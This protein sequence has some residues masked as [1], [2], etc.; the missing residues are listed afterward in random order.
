VEKLLWDRQKRDKETTSVPYVRPVQYQVK[1][2]NKIPDP[3]SKTS[4]MIAF[5]RDYRY[6]ATALNR[7][8]KCPLQFYYSMVLGLKPKGEIT[9]DI[10]RD[11][12]GSFIH[13]I[14]RRYFLNKRGKPL[15]EEDLAIGEMDSLVEALFEKEYGKE[16]TGALYLLKRQVKRRMADILKYYYVPLSR[17]NELTILEVEESLEVRVDGF[18]LKG[19]LDSI[20]QRGGKTVIVDFKTGASESYLKINLEKLDIARRETWGQAI[21]SLQLP[22]YLLL[23][24]EKK[25]RPIDEFNALFLLLGRSRISEAIELSLFDDASPAETFVPLKAV[26]FKLLG[27][28]IDPRVPF[29]LAGDMKNGCP[30]CDFKYICG[31]PWVVK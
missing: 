30:T 25:R 4:E 21:G 20:E 18:N 2:T 14:L 22:L 23:Y 6:S 31:T 3:I 13:N 19:R 10:E 1:L 24:T 9:G 27:E 16:T 29:S 28:I 5:L 7:Y 15:K 12:L 11:E 26:I 8:L 17:K